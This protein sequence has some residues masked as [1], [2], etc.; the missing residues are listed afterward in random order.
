[1][2]GVLFFGLSAFVTILFVKSGYEL[3][4]VR[5]YVNQIVSYLFVFYHVLM[6]GLFGQTIGKMLLDVKV[7]R[8]LDETEIG[9]RHAVLRDIMP[10]IVVAI[11]ALFF[12]ANFVNPDGSLVVGLAFAVVALLVVMPL[13]NVAELITMLFN[14]KRRAIHDFIAGTVV[15]RL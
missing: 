13:W 11:S 10:L 2:D 6:H 5:E 1:M 12:T 4:V 14:D 8:A 15:I 9:F 3:A 7:V